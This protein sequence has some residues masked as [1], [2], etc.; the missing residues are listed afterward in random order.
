MV[1]DL[2]LDIVDGIAIQQINL[3]R[4]TMNDTQGFKLSLNSIIMDGFNKIIIDFSNC[5]YIDSS[6]I[7]LLITFTKELRKS[8]GDIKLIVPRNGSVLNI[9]V[10]TSLNKIFLQFPDR[11]KALD[12]FRN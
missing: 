6:V 1:N 12:S 11:Q 7:G 5:T 4:L 2:V 9:F 8:G 10:Q 3:I